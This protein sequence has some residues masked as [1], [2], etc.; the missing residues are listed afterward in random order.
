MTGRVDCDFQPV[1]VC[2]LSMV[3]ECGRWPQSASKGGKR[4][5]A[6]KRRPDR[7]AKALEGARPRFQIVGI[8]ASAGGLEAYKAFFRKSRRT[9]Q[10]FV[11]YRI[12]ILSIERDARLLSSYTPCRSSRRRTAWSYR[13][14]TPT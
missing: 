4:S 13:R 10:A 3:E 6:R 1:S 2:I 12:W 14:I 5:N 9:A 8:G 7:A 11:A